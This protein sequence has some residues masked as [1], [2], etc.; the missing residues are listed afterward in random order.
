LLPL[1]ISFYWGRGAGR[2]A[3]AVVLMALVSLAMQG[4]LLWTGD[5]P[6]GFLRDLLP[7]GQPR[8]DQHSF[9][10]RETWAWAYRIPV[11]VVFVAFVGTT[12]FW[13]RPKNLAH[14]TALSAAV[15]TGL[16]LWYAEQGGIYVF[17]YL[18]LVLFLMFRPNLADRRPFPIVPETD[19]LT[20]FRGVLGRL[21]ARRTG[22]T[23]PVVRVS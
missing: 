12:A 9:W 14:L 1:W 23:Q 3:G 19:W 4:T 17:W 6:E 21:L 11:F 5:L 7:F 22:P 2:F 15:L 13:P 20:R 16:Q 8:S 18:P 10:T